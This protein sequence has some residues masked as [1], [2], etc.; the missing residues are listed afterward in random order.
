MT[1]IHAHKNIGFIT[2]RN[3]ISK[4]RRFERSPFD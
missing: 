2:T 4:I 3:D 1:G